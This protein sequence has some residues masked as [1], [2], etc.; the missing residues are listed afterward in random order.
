MLRDSDD[1]RAYLN[2]I[3]RIPLMTPAE[4]IACGKKVQ[5]A[6]ALRD[7]DRPLTAAEKR[8]VR[9]GER[10]IKRF[11]E[12]NLRLVV[13][14]AKRY[15]YR[16][17]F[18][19]MSD[20]I[21]EGTIG[22]MRAAELFDPGRG[23][24]FSTY[25][26]WWIR[27]GMTRAM[28]NQERSIRR[29]AHICDLGSRLRKAI[30][31]ETLRLGR[32]PNRAEVAEAAGTTVDEI[33]TYMQRGV[34]TASL[35]ALCGSEQESTILDNIPD[36]NS[37]DREEVENDLSFDLQGHLFG[38]CF[39]RLTEQ[40]RVFMIQRYG[41]N[42]EPPMTLKEIGDIAGLSRERIRQITTRAARKMRLYLT[43]QGLGPDDTHKALRSGQE[44]AELNGALSASA[45]G[46]RLPLVTPE[47]PVQQCG[48]SL[49]LEQ[50][51]A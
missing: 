11:V 35:D 48:T 4:E 51:A 17:D 26:Y 38:A 7:L 5:A 3:G 49:S 10:A 6:K 20:L 18:M 43:Q 36:P 21:Q 15:Q 47:A 22:L 50:T 42:N 1:L 24:K 30:Q 14:V 13:S 19:L 25:C 8:I 29:P 27:Q 45:L 44:D 28:N 34:N 41:L 33:E 16:C 40:E 2:G 37:L 31:G 39:S 23:Y 46:S 9:Q 32:Q 12:G